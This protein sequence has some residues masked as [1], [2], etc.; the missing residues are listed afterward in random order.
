MCCFQAKLFRFS[1]PVVILADGLFYRSIIKQSTRRLY[2]SGDTTSKRRWSKIDNIVFLKPFFK[3]V[4]RKSIAS[5][6]QWTQ[7]RI[8]LRRYEL[9]PSLCRSGA[10]GPLAGLRKLS[11]GT[12]P[13]MRRRN[14]GLR[15]PLW[16][17]KAC[18]RSLPH[19]CA[20]GRLFPLVGCAM[21]RASDFLY[22]PCFFAFFILL[23]A[24]SRRNS[25]ARRPASSSTLCRPS[26]VNMVP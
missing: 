15:A 25:T 7:R 9:T 17:V 22:T 5:S 11:S 2:L 21:I 24:C 8:L 1:W 23:S 14:R 6:H 18:G 19:N 3:I 26:P 4:P 16:A 13:G 20:S 12:Q 10:G